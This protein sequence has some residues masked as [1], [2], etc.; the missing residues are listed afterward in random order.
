MKKI[1]IILLKKID[2][3]SAV[4]CRLTVLTGKSKYPIH[5]KHLVG[6]KLWFK[7]A[8]NKNDVVLDLGSGPG[9]TS[10]KI[11]SLTKKVIGL[12]IDS[13]LLEIANKSTKSR[14]QKNIIFIQGDANMGLPFRNNTFDK[15]LCSDVLEHLH[16]REFALKEIYRVL[17]KGGLLLLV[18]DNPDTSWK[19]IQKSAGIFYYADLDHKYE[20]PKDEIL[21]ILKSNNFK[22][23][24][25]E[26]T[27]YDTPFRG[28]I[29]LTGGISLP[30]YKKL[31]QWREA[32]NQKY[33]KETTGYRIIAVKI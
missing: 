8:L 7:E 25:L 22:V 32:M 28:L 31:R 21:N 13:K 20:Y 1:L 15:I 4:A 26:T 2:I 18:T 27:T 11:A 23:L 19:K 33:P 16:K 9:M 14:N 29:D 12:E 30:I 24:K 17:K 3:L 6:Q 5:P 10:L